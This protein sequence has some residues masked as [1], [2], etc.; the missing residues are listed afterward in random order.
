MNMKHDRLPMGASNTNKHTCPRHARIVCHVDM[1]DTPPA[2]KT[3]IG[4]RNPA[5]ETHEL[6][7]GRAL[8]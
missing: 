5:D 6:L 8:V 1:H 7:Q 2:G 3:P 4:M